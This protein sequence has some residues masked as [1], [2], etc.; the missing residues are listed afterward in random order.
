MDALD[1]EVVR[2]IDDNSLVD[3]ES[4]QR[5]YRRRGAQSLTPGFYVVLWPDPASRP[6]YDVRA[7]FVGPFES[8]IVA[9]AA[10]EGPRPVTL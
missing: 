1:F 8:D 10:M 5:S 4:Y 6:R 9:R 7:E 3:S 2:V